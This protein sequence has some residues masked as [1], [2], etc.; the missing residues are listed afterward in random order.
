MPTTCK[1]CGT[2][3]G[4][5]LIC[6]VCNPGGGDTPSDR[7]L[8]AGERVLVMERWNPRS[9]EHYLRAEGYATLIERSPLKPTIAPDIE[10]WYVRLDGTDQLVLRSVYA[11]DRVAAGGEPLDNNRPMA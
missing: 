5:G 2:I 6:H 8:Q 7:P 9:G 3:Y 11:R 1:V 4:F 10:S